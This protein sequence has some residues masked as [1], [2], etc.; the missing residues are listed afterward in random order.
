MNNDEN[1]QDAGA[2]DLALTVSE[3]SDS[4]AVLA[5]L[6][7]DTGMVTQSTVQCQDTAILN[8]PNDGIADGLWGAGRRH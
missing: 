4:S 1:A 3:V 6:D 5:A 8:F 7:Y 2:S